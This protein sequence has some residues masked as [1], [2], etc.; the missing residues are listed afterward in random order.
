[1]DIFP[2]KI[3]RDL[4]WCPPRCVC[5][6]NPSDNRSFIFDDFEL[7]G[8]ARCR[9]ISVSSPSCVSAF[10]YHTGHAAADLLR[11]VLALHLSDEAADPNQD[12]VRSAIVDGLDL[13]PLE[14]Q[15]FV[16]AGQILH[17]T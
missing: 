6:K 11:A 15:P 7:A 1:M 13:D 2:I 12:G 5:C 17:V 3:L 4:S 16:N 9:S 10:A 14:R 8:L